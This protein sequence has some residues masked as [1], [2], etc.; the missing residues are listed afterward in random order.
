MRHNNRVDLLRECHFFEFNGSRPGLSLFVFVLCV[1]TFAR[2]LLLGRL[3]EGA[4]IIPRTRKCSFRLWAETTQITKDL[5][6][7]GSRDIVLRLKSQPWYFQWFC[8]F[9]LPAALKTSNYT[10]KLWK[11]IDKIFTEQIRQIYSRT[12]TNGHLLRNL[13]KKLL[14]FNSFTSLWTG[15]LKHT[16]NPK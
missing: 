13:E 8:L 14:F 4:S 7:H 11:H 12:S 9:S 5:L 16:W 15:S 1:L 10:T 2:V 6:N 3:Q